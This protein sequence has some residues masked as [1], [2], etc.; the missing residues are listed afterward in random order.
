MTDQKMKKTDFL[1]TL[2]LQQRNIGANSDLQN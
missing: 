1:L 2:R